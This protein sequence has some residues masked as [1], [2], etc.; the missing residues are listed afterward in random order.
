MRELE[1]PQVKILNARMMGRAE[2]T[3]LTFER[4][5]LP[6][7]GIFDGGV[8]HCYQHRPRPQFCTMCFGTGHRADVCPDSNRPRCRNFAQI[9][10]DLAQEHECPPCSPNCNGGH[11]ADDPDCE[12]HCTADK[13]VRQAAHLKRLQLRE[14]EHAAN[15]EPNKVPIETP[16]NSRSRSRSRYRS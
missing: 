2:I 11:P 6:R 10:H 8:H 15:D 5:S 7:R 4:P 13:V 14:E 9:I 1:A 3:I 12:V 16:S